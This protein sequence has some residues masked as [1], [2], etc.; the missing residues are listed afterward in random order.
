MPFRYPVALEVANRRCIVIGGGKIA[1]HKARE[2]VEAGAHVTVVA[3]AFSAELEEMAQGGAVDLTRRPYR[4]GDLEGAFIAIA[5][6]DDGGVNAEVYRDGRSRNVLVNCVD[7]IEHCDFAAPS[8]IRRGDLMVTISTGGKAPALAKR[9]RIDLSERIGREYEDLVRLL[10][11]VREEVMPLRKELDFDTWAGRW[12]NALEGNLL[13]IVRSGEHESLKQLVRARLYEEED[14]ATVRATGHGS[15]GW[16]AIVGAGPGDPSLITVRGKE[17]LGSADVVVHDRLIHPDLIADKTAVYAGKHGGFEST[18]QESIN[19]LLVRLALKGRNVVRLKGGDPFVFG[20]GSE[21]AEALADA[22]IPY[23]VVPAPTSAIAALAYA[24]IP[25]TDRRFA[26][27]VA[28]VTGHSAEKDPDWTALAS[29]VDTIVVLMGMKRLEDIARLM[30]DGGLAPSTPS[31]VVENGTLSNQRVV[32][33]PLGALHERVTAAGLGS[34]A[35]LV[36]GE[37]VRLR[38]GIAWFDEELPEPRATASLD[39]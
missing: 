5:A 39:P 29:A 8:V 32:T 30:I 13:E 36:V 21:E 15:R 38:K 27:S 4:T 26:S 9:L 25:V 35:V 31:A 34:P 6:T 11:E 22:G 37:V 12:H 2:L 7:D 10:G 14:A 19:S 18:P 23:E 1:T 33:A 17:L 24:G 16:V 20:R 3:G 28:I